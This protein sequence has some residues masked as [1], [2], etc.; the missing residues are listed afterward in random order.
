[1]A[2]FSLQ[3]QK[4]P[5]ATSRLRPNTLPLHTLASCLPINFFSKE[6][7]RTLGSKDVSSDCSREFPQTASTDVWLYVS[8]FL[9]F[10]SLAVQVI[11]RRYFSPAPTFTTTKVT[12]R[13]ESLLKKK[14]LS[15]ASPDGHHGEPPWLI[16]CIK[17]KYT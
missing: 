3:V 7:S 12:E 5:N 8:A 10:K 11:E 6:S 2:A 16:L 14:T 4:T 9:S 15:A 1:M 17:Y 13:H